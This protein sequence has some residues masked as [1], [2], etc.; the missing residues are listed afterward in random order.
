MKR[1][2]A[3]GAASRFC[4]RHSSAV[5]VKD[6]LETNPSVV[7]YVLK[8]F[9]KRQSTAAIAKLFCPNLVGLT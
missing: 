6:L 1:A 2:A 3:R 8:L 9:G 4:P 7:R 5:I